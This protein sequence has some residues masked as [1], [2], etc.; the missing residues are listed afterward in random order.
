MKFNLKQFIF[1]CLFI[2]VIVYAIIT[3]FET[4][5]IPSFILKPISTEASFQKELEKRIEINIGQ[6]LEKLFGEGNYFVSVVIRL[7]QIN[8]AVEMITYEPMSITKNISEQYEAESFLGNNEANKLNNENRSNSTEMDPIYSGM[9]PIIQG[10]FTISDEKFDN[11]AIQSIVKIPE[12]IDIRKISPKINK[13]MPG[14]PYMKS[15]KSSQI[16]ESIDESLKENKP[17]NDENKFNSKNNYSKI[18]NNKEIYYN[19]IK[20]KTE[21]PNK[22]IDQLFVSIMIDE[23]SFKKHNIS[24]E[25]LKKL[26]SN[27]ATLNNNRGDKLV[28]SIMPFTKKAFNWKEIYLTYKIPFQNLMI[29]PKFKWTLIGFVTF[30]ITGII[31][32]TGFLMFRRFEKEQA[33]RKAVLDKQ[34]EE[35][36]AKSQLA[37]ANQLEQRKNDIIKLAKSKPQ[38]F[39][40]IILNWIEKT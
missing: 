2:G 34:Q 32:F 14:F 36:N 30:F 38:N 17:A 33:Q 20:R 22:K 24:E 3:V 15:E 5:I 10:K 8:E 11:N 4:V 16:E 12:L 27:I 13:D 1:A 19:Q 18:L 26:V 25:M 31:S 39:A 6:L 23:S 35:Q 40:K 7:H 29:T 37:I 9:D 28:I 21:T